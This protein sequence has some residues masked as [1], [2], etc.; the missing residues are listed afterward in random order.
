MCLGAPRLE[1]GVSFRLIIAFSE[2]VVP[3]G[4]G[5]LFQPFWVD[6]SFPKDKESMNYDIVETSALLPQLLRQE[7]LMIVWSLDWGGE[8]EEG[9]QAGKRKG[10]RKNTWSYP[11]AS[12]CGTTNSLLPVTFILF[13]SVTNLRALHAP[14]I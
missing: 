5:R 13:P 10:W 2:T 4:S 12:P 1:W 3:L 6:C 14:C 11:P 9:N 7:G 8:P